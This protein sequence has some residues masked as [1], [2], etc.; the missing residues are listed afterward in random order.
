MEG[1]GRDLLQYVH[2]RREMKVYSMLAFPR[3]G[4]YPRQQ[5]REHDSFEELS[6]LIWK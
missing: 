1:C 4:S 5:V 6:H 3:G 2:G